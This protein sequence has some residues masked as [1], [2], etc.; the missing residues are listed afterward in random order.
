[1]VQQNS[2]PSHDR[3]AKAKPKAPVS[4]CIVKLMV[5]FEDILKLTF[6]DSRAG[7]PNLD[8]QDPIISPTPEQDLPSLGIFDR[9]REQ[10]SYHLLEQARIATGQELARH[11]VQ[12]DPLCLRLACEVGGYSLKQGVDPERFQLR[13]DGSGLDL[14]DVEQRV[15]HPRHASQGLTEP[16]VQPFCLLVDDAL[17]EKLLQQHKRLQ[18]LTKIVACGCEKSGFG[19]VGGVC[20]SSGA[21]QGRGRF[22]MM[23]NVGKRYDQTFNTLTIRPIW[24]N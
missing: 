19:H 2:E 7:I 3:E 18:R 14:V 10:I 16:N 5:L 24:Q 11:H 1:M 22:L 13:S 6:G 17:R 21:F 8:A 9:V 4:G 12:S 15:Q 23:G 20:L